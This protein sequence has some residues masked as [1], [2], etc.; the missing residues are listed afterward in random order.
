MLEL[1]GCSSR[2]SKSVDGKVVVVL[3]VVL[4]VIIDV[5]PLLYAKL[6]SKDLKRSA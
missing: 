5:V 3:V 4:S 1:S 6:S 2:S